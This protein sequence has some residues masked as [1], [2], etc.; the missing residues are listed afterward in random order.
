MM[1]CQQ[2]I[3]A[4][5]PSVG[6]YVF[7][8][9]TSGAADEVRQSL[10]R[11]SE[12]VDGAQVLVGLGLE[13]V[14]KLGAQVHG[15]HDFV[16]L[17]GPGVT[18]PA[19]PVALCC[20]LRGED[21][22]DLLQLTRQLQKTLQPVFHLDKVVDAFRHG[23]GRDLTGYEDGTENPQDDAAVAT[24]LVQGAGA[25]RDGSSFMV[26]QQWLHD[27]DAFDAMS[28]QAQDHMVGRRRTDN[29]ELD[30]A[31]E[32]A[33]VKRTAQESFEPEAFVLRRSM[34][35][36]LGMQS[37]LMF[38]AF[39][40]SLDAFEVQMRRMAGLEDGVVDALFGMSRPLTGANF[41]CPPMIEGRLDWRQLGL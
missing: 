34:P 13:V 22:G 11:L 8:S 23:S 21:R 24:A 2:A 15:L 18:V 4:G 28:Q 39:G 38:V 36:N 20:W 16:A 25:G 33:H 35:W 17:S 5:V 3:L 6:R 29:E 40:H 12:R 19:T 37:G 1:H 9:L 30:D 7:F 32:S 14:R 10:R 27:L 26:V 31:P 41:W